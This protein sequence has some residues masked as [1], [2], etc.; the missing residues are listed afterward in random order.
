MM[1][2]QDQKGITLIEMMVVL[3]IVG[4]LVTIAI[5]NYQA[6]VSDQN[7]RSSMV[8]LA[9]DL[10]IAR[11]TAINRNAPI[12][13]RFDDVAMTYTAFI[14]NGAVA[15]GGVNQVQARDLIQNGTEA[16]IFT[17]NNKPL[18]ARVSISQVNFGANPAVLFNGRGMRGIPQA[19]PAQVVLQND[20]GKQ[21]QINVTLVGD[22]NVAAP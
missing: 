18:N 19:D 13:V 3:A 14:D 16:A 9:G 5:P 1:S 4:V 21:Y 20:R 8:Q 2:R 7:L 22:V 15:G 11:M 17:P 6:W 10:Q 12:T